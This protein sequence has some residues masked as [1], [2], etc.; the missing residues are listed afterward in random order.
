MKKENELARESEYVCVGDRPLEARDHET[1][2]DGP[3]TVRFRL[4]TL[5]PRFKVAI[6]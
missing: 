5:P 6:S 4:V 1:R 2:L 3:S